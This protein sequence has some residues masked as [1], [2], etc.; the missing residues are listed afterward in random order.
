MLSS[1][2]IRVLIADTHQMV[3][4]SLDLLLEIAGGFELVGQASDGAEAVR[5]CHQFQPDAALMGLRLTGLDGIAAT[6]LIREQSP[7]THV[8]ILTTSIQQEEEAAAFQAGASAFLKKTCRVRALSIRYELYVP[9]MVQ[10]NHL[11]GNQLVRVTGC[12]ERSNSVD[13]RIRGDSL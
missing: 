1:R 4:S 12:I 10:S 7:K 11:T 3:R 8:I 6:R 5:L 2:T 13:D 9:Q